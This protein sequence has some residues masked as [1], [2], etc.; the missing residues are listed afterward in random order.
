MSRFLLIFLI[1]DGSDIIKNSLHIE[2]PLKYNFD[3][4]IVDD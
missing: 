1:D 2:H 4:F 3:I